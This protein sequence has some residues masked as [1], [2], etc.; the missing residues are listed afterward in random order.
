MSDSFMKK[1]LK[2]WNTEIFPHTWTPDFA[3]VT[4]YIG[5]VFSR[6]D[7]RIPFE[8]RRSDLCNVIWNSQYTDD[9]YLLNRKRTNQIL[10]QKIIES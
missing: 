8:N 6:H 2:H 5:F 4:Q 1:I 3:L 10:L 7:I 9:H